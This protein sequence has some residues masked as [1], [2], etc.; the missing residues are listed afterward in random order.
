MHQD[1]DINMADIVN[2]CNYVKY[3]EKV[4]SINNVNLLELRG[5]SLV[6]SLGC[7]QAS[8]WAAAVFGYSDSS[9]DCCL[10]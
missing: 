3:M 2:V 9:D 7:F 1:F 4:T 6:T 5:V 8:D 10:G